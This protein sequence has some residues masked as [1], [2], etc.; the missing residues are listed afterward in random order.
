VVITSAI[1]SARAARAALQD[2]LVDVVGDEDASRAGSRFFADQ[3][4]QA[5]G[6]GPGQ[7][8]YGD[9]AAPFE[10]RVTRRFLCFPEGSRE[11]MSRP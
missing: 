11:K 4:F 1:R 2:R 8:A 10:R 6:G 9:R 7:W 5:T 3:V